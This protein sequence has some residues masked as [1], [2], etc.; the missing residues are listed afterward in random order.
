MN[1][2]IIILSMCVAIL[3]MTI[4]YSAFISNIKINGTANITST[5]NILF[6]DIKEISKTDG[7]NVK[8][9]PTISGTLATFN[10][11]LNYP[12]DN[13]VYEI[14][15]ENK[16]TIDAVINSINGTQL[17][18]DV[19][20]FIIDGIK[21]GDKLGH[22]ESKNF[23]VTIKYKDVTKDPNL[24]DNEL[25]IDITYIQDLEGKPEKEPDI[26][27]TRL[28][29]KILYDNE[30]KSDT[31]I[32]FSQISSDTN[33][34]GLYYTN[35][36]TEDNRV[37]YYFRGAVDNNY[38]YFAGY[39]WRIIRIN[40]DGSI[41]LIYQGEKIDATGSNAQIGT[42]I[43]NTAIGDNS[44]AGYMHGTPTTY[45]DG[46]GNYSGW[47]WDRKTGTVKMGTDY[48]FDEKTGVY[49]LTG[50]VDAHYDED[51]HGYYT[52]YS[53]STA[54]THMI[55]ITQTKEEGDNYQIWGGEIYS[56]YWSTSYEQAHANEVDSDIKIKLEDWYQE[57]L[58][59]YDTYI[60][61]TG[62]CNDRSL[63]SGYEKVGFGRQE[64][65]YE[66]YNRLKT[67]SNP[68]FSCPNPTHDLFT[69][70]N[71]KGN[72]K[73]TKKVGLI[74]ADEAVYAGGVYN[75]ENSSYYL[76]TGANYWTMSPFCFYSA[77]S[78]MV[79][80]SVASNGYLGFSNVWG[81]YGVRPVI[82]LKANIEIT[83]INEDGTISNPYV[84]KTN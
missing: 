38:V 84:I 26:I 17:G 78:R 39:Y 79:D 23:T 64:T 25:Q 35:T 12:G 70:T 24:K 60:A 74:T 20:E 80:Y 75:V 45:T 21:E 59:T 68:Q 36:N 51:H 82:N 37:T 14:T 44:M 63:A 18:S 69:V 73:S 33:G 57:H 11:G 2:K 42:S 27:P 1:K 83:D 28:S 31:G 40:E 54:C 29:Q 4:G 8:E 55:K 56:G 77:A 49:T 72:K 19:I 13:I 65:Y 16:G 30:E 41:R 7:V 81:A 61:D 71:E 6:T 47:A 34:K 76:Y 66:A 67:K 48:T 10:I 5:W 50:V 58:T 32:N 46:H 15:V 9:D 3:I 53:Q 62:F 52:C 43:F 22:G